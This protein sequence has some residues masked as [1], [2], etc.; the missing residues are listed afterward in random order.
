MVSASTGLVSWNIS[1]ELLWC[2][3]PRNVEGI[4]GIQHLA[5][6]AGPGGADS[7][8]EVV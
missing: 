2:R 3:I 5:G 6:R 4:E 7:G 8:Q 1:W